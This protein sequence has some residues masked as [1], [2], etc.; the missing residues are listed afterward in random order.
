M[1][2]VL[3]YFFGVVV[4]LFGLASVDGWVF[5]WWFAI[6]GWLGVSCAGCCGVLTLM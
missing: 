2:W 6:A 5:L 1:V 3:L 4:C